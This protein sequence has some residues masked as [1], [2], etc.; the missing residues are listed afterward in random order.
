MP[1]QSSDTAATLSITLQFK[2]G[3]ERAGPV[4]SLSFTGKA[5]T[6]LEVKRFPRFLLLSHCPRTLPVTTLA[7]KAGKVTIYLFWLYSGGQQKRRGQSNTRDCGRITERMQRQNATRH[8]AGGEEL[9]SC[10]SRPSPQFLRGLAILSAPE[11]HKIS[12]CLSNKSL[13]HLKLAF[14]DAFLANE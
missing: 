14:A 13:P 3:E 10:F 5:K 2:A 1:P 11:F 6:F 12:P 4:P 7:L 9:C 8:Q